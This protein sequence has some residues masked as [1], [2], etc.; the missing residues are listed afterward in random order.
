MGG[1]TWFVPTSEQTSCLLSTLNQTYL[2]VSTGLDTEMNLVI[3]LFEKESRL[4]VNSSLTTYTIYAKIYFGIKRKIC[5]EDQ[6]VH[7]LNVK[8]HP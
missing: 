4:G 6:C 1:Q 2:N 8:D 7:W 5:R 3:V